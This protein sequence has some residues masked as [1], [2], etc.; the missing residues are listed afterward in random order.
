MF[1][2]EMIDGELRGGN[3]EED[4]ALAII[5]EDASLEMKTLA[6][7]S[8]AVDECTTQQCSTP[9]RNLVLTLFL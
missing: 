7:E 6:R 8:R 9:H 2:V 3:D 1:M 5:N 4:D